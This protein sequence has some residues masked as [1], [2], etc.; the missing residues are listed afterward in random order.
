MKK[1][2]DFIVIGGGPNGLTTAAYLSK[3][4]QSVLVLERNIEVGGG[5]ATEEITLGGFR[6][7]THAIY[8]MMTEYA[9][10]YQDLELGN[11]NY[12]CRYL[13]PPLKVVMPFTDGKCLCLYKDVD[14]S[15]ASIAKLSRKDADTYREV[16]HKFQAYMDEVLAPATYVNPTPALEQIVAMESTP[17]GKEVSELTSKSPQ[18]IVEELFENERVKTLMLYLACHW[19][20]EHDVDGVGY[21]VP[22]MINRAVNAKLCVGGSHRL[23]NALAR[24]IQEPGRGLLL[25]S[26]RIKRIII[27]DGTAKGVELENGTIY[28]AEKG[29]ISSIDPH[30]TFLKLVGEKN[31]SKDLAQALK[32]WKWEKWSLFSVH[33]ALEK[34]PNFTAAAADPEINKSLMYVMGYETP[35]DLF[36][37][38]QAIGKGELGAK[39]GFNCCFATIHDPS[40][41]PPG[42]HTGLISEMAPYNLK[43]NAEK[44]Y[45]IKLREEHEKRCLETLRRYAPNM[46]KENIL[47]TYVMTPVDFANKL[48]DMVQGSIKQGA[49]H[50]LQMGYNRPNSELSQYKTPIKG[51]YLCGASCHPG[52]LVTFGAGYN[53]A[54]VIAEDLG[55]KKWWSESKLVTDYRKKG[56]V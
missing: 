25:G 56:Y 18:T 53:A 39:C 32:Q 26:Q 28:E 44:W 46:T 8:H 38:W 10:V 29:V 17:L 2:Y 45:D 19:G 48:V 21:L 47:W 55:L 40:Q 6:H 52:G 12:R 27:T 36:D 35:Q 5:L 9:P 11:D 23:S 15:C 16:A 3:A 1:K 54:N 20:L 30:Q 42:R 31:I 43:K 49:Y 41:A 37:Q 51:L 4:G 7:N 24:V 34:A 33:L 13:D 22:L 14:K 50:P